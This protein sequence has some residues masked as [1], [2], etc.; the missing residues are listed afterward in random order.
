M[1]QPI[2]KTGVL[3][4]NLGTP[5][6]TSLSSIR[7]YLREFLLDPRVID[8][9]TIPR[10]L[11]V[12][13]LIVPFRSPKTAKAYQKI[14]QE[15]GSPLRIHS[16][17]LADK[18]RSLLGD[19]HQVELAMRYGN[20]SIQNAVTK[21]NHCQKII[22][23]PLFPQY[24]SAATGS[25]IEKAMSELGKQ[26]NIPSINII[27]QF[28]AHP[29]FIRALASSIKP[30]IDSAADANSNTKTDKFLLLSYH[31]LPERH[32]DKSNCKASCSRIKPC[33]AMSTQNHF[34]YRA[35][36]FA[37]SKLLANQLGLNSDQYKTTFQ[38]RL[39]KLPWIQ[40]YTDDVLP[41][42]IQR[43]IKKLVV[44]CPAFTADCLETLEEIG[45]EAKKQWLELGGES[46]ELVPC[47][48]SADQWVSCVA[49]FIKQN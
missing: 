41:K 5:D 13:G 45:M 25:A 37:T 20:P 44:A 16:Q 43:D 26:W 27:D 38:S 32:I 3:L 14:W 30:Y 23:L 36:C 28:Y 9:P 12:N 6:D 47:L 1:S 46:F 17:A 24:S 34:C 40:P 39:G 4:I 33:P 7:R 18:A 21:L 8:L 29:D 31:G 35:Q 42:L 15:N 19:N 49:N 2:L 11:L 10:Y 48:N 22:I